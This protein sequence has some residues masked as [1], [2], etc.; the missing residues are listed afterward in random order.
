METGAR[1]VP[2]FFFRIRYI[3]ED[4]PNNIPQNTNRDEYWRPPYDHNH[5]QK[6]QDIV[7]ELDNFQWQQDSFFHW[8]P[9]R[10]GLYSLPQ[11][12]N[13]QPYK[14]ASLFWNRDSQSYLVLP[15]DCTKRST[16]RPSQSDSDSSATG[17]SLH[18]ESA[19]NPGQTP[20]GTEQAPMLWQRLKFRRD[21]RDAILSFVGYSEEY[22][23][24]GAPIEDRWSFLLP[25]TN[26][27]DPDPSQTSNAQLGGELTIILGLIAFCTEERDS[28]RAI[29]ESFFPSTHDSDWRHTPFMKSFAHSKLSLT[30]PALSVSAQ[31]LT[32]AQGWKRE[33]WS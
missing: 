30:A 8:R 21:Q 18:S 23:R 27:A 6:R 5:F 2:W 9:G 10:V 25:A 20:D 14:C 33:A 17:P 15:F 1:D 4:L 3:R 22:Q 16:E 26:F 31:T 29:Q 13:L 32:Q 11:H 7:Y 12:G 24:L 19:S 28:I